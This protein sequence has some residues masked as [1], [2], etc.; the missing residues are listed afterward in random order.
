MSYLRGSS[1]C[2]SPSS[3]RVDEPFMEMKKRCIPGGFNSVQLESQKTLISKQNL[4]TY[5]FLM[6][7]FGAVSG[8]ISKKAKAGKETPTF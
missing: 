2:K 3:A 7:L 6:K 4:D 8:L 5:I 1:S